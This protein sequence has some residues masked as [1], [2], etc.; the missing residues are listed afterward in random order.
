M[1]VVWTPVHVLL[2]LL[3]LVHRAHVSV[4]AATCTGHCCCA[5]RVAVAC[6]PL[7]LLMLLLRSMVHIPACNTP[8]LRPCT[9]LVVP[10]H[11]VDCN[12]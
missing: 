11:P 5:A 1:G 10:L 2:L 4:K 8:L 6:T 9:P 7:L 12:T 3:P